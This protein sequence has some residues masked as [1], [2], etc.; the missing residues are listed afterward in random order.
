MPRSAPALTDI[1]HTASETVSNNGVW[2]GHGLCKA[3]GA[4]GDVV[5]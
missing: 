2:D 5:C 1:M 4:P 3:Y